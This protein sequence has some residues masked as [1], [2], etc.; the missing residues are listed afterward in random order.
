AYSVQR[1]SWFSS[2]PVTRYRMRSTGRN[3]GSRKVFSLLNTRAMKMPS[4][5]VTRKTSNRKNKICNQPF[6]VISKFL[7]TKHRERQIRKQQRAQRQHRHVLQTHNRS[8]R[9]RSQK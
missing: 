7:S 1:I 9:T 8:Y 6:G 4:G 3:T 5:F 2:T